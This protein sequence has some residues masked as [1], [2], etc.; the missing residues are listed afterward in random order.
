MLQRLFNI[1]RLVMSMNFNVLSLFFALMVA[2]DLLA[3][4]KGKTASKTDKAPT[5]I[6]EVLLD[7]AKEAN[8]KNPLKI[9]ANTTLQNV[10]VED[11]LNFIRT[12]IV[13][14]DRDQFKRILEP[15]KE[16][17]VDY[18]CKDQFMGQLIR[19]HGVDFIYEYKNSKGEGVG[20]FYVDAV[21]CNLPQV[22]VAFKVNKGCI[23]GVLSV[24]SKSKHL[25]S[26]SDEK[27][28]VYTDQCSDRVTSAMA[29]QS[30][31]EMN[32]MLSHPRLF[33]CNFGVGLMLSEILPKDD[34]DRTLKDTKLLEELLKIYCSEL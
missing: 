15:L 33:G 32:Q 13:N 4:E 34:L 6:N 11:D 28:K 22:P 21:D 5:T 26:L 10:R 12:Y 9:D 16:R 14:W 29:N 8:K 2:P 23:N 30:S 3:S 18:M 1:R 17:N 7:M 24:I 19:K 27:K 31:N 20:A 25:K